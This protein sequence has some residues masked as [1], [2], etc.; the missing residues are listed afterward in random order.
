MNPQRRPK[1]KPAG[2]NPIV[3]NVGSDATTMDPGKMLVPTSPTPTSTPVP[4]MSTGERIAIGAAAFVIV[5]G[6]GYVIS[7]SKAA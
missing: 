1:Q 6:L 2:A 3:P 5:L 7:K 4:S